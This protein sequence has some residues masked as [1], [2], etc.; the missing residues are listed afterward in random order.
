MTADS[1]ITANGADD[2]G[3]VACWCCDASDVADRM[4][5]LGNHPEVH[6]C[7]RCAHFVH[8]QAW[9]IEDDT[10]RGSAA[11]V[12]ERFRS[13]RA[14]VMRHGWHQNRIIGGTLRWLGKHLP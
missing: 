4:V 14:L 9:E 2:E 5:Q 11:F 7:L 12:R 6:L 3:D 10:K 13:L 8:Q 1:T